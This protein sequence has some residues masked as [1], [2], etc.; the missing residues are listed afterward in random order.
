MALEPS[1]YIIGSDQHRNGK[2]ML[3]R[4]LVDYLMLDG[5]DPFAIDAGFPLGP[6]RN[7]FPGRTALVDFETVRGQMK[8]F[9]T[10]LGTPG[11]DYVIDFTADQTQRFAKAA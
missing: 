1:V 5:R 10:I 9:D 6:L 8:V 2:T 4:V 11:R 7:H 3:A